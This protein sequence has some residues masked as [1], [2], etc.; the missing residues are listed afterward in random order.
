VRDVLIQD[1][2]QEI[3]SVALPVIDVGHEIA[4]RLKLAI[5]SGL[6]KPGCRIKQQNLA[7]ICSVSRMPVREALRMLGVQG[8]LDNQTNKGY[9]VASALPNKI[10]RTS[11]ND[12]IIPL[13]AIY[14]LLESPEA[15]TQFEMSIIQQL[16]S[17]DKLH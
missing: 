13:K 10:S 7:D 8:Y 12:L 1:I 17:L 11:F 4:L 6:L 2:L 3:F 9:V 15:R 16:R 14:E 5:E